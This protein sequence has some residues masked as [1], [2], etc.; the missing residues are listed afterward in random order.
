MVVVTGGI[1]VLSKI[2][3]KQPNI[4]SFMDTGEAEVNGLT[5]SS[6]VEYTSLFRSKAPVSLP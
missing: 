6:N 4:A 1:V 5:L 2:C 3:S